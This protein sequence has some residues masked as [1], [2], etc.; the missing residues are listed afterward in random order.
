MIY[1]N[2]SLV[3]V[4]PKN[5]SKQDISLFEHEI[6][7]SFELSKIYYFHLAL[8]DSAGVFITYKNLPK[9]VQEKTSIYKISINKWLYFILKTYVK[10]KNVFVYKKAV[11]VTDCWSTGYFHWM[12]DSLPRLLESIVKSETAI[13]LPANFVSL[14]FVIPSLEAMGFYNIKFMQANKYYLF[15]H[16]IF[17]THS[18]PTGN[19]NEKT[20]RQLR[21]IL[22]SKLKDDSINLGERIFVSREKAER[23]KLINETDFVSILENFGFSIIYFENYSWN[24]QVSICSKAKYLIG[25]HGAGLSNMLFMPANSVVLE[26]RKVGDSH[27]NCYFSLASA[28]GHSYYYLQCKTNSVEVLNADFIVDKDDFQLLLETIFREATLF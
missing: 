26:F 16:L 2:N 22:T 7:R 4:Y 20:I 28:L 11:W 5:I 25:L 8:I 27:N 17:N 18:A 13:F 10:F 9:Q 3:R 12:L 6:Y 21:D 14:P 1:E 19:Y 15:N 23:R 24:E